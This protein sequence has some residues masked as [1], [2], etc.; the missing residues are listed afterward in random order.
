MSQIKKGAILNYATILTT[1]LVGLLITPFIIRYL[2]DEEFGL[3]NLIGAFVG[4]ISILD[5]GLSNTIIRFVAKYQAEK[6]QKGEANFLATTLIIYG[7]ISI[8]VL[9]IGGVCY[10]NLEAIF[11]DSLSPDEIGKAKIMFAILVFALAIGLPAN[12]FEGICF[13][14]ER[15]AYPKAAKLIRYLVRS[16]LV[17]GLLLLGGKAVALVILDVT[18]NIILF[19]VILYYVFRKIK[20]HIR[21]YSWNRELLAKIFGY[22]VWIFIFVLVGQFQWKVGQ[23]VLGVMTNT[24][25]VA[26]FAIG[27]M[28]GSY[29]GAF[30][31]AITGVLLPRATQMTVGNAS[32]E[33]LTNMMIKVGRLSFIVLMYILGAFLLYGQQFIL[34]WVGE[35]Y[36]DSWWIALIIMIAY[37]L[38]LVQGFGNSI[39]EAC[40]KLRFKAIVY[41]TFLILGTLLG[42]YLTR[43]YGAIGMI[44]GSVTG[45]MIG[46]NIMNFYYHF[47]IHLNIPRFFLGLLQKTLVSFLIILLIGYAIWWIPGSG[48]INFG[49]KAILY[50]GV[51]AI[52]MYRWGLNSF[53]RNLIL[54]VI[55]ARLLKS[56]KTK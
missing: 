56:G 12:A 52:I 4:Y 55:P 40:N 13:G 3:F 1:N 9:L 53:E 27:V 44:L 28:L 21:L 23:L 30:S 38:P 26:I 2:G 39:L 54:Q 8:L 36:G 11:A 46:Q 42:A 29:Y 50:S 15:F 47:K 32:A 33:E 41:L 37:T 20:V 16:V 7:F 45:W 49:L 22:S 35:T 18:L 14:Y 48:W 17:I 25:L 31:S 43:S 6:D 10:M 34:L 51:Y 19:G 24:T 5:F